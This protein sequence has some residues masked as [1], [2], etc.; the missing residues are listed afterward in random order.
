M[1]LIVAGKEHMNTF[2]LM[3]IYAFMHSAA[4]K[5]AFRLSGKKKSMPLAM[6]ITFSGLGVHEKA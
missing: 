6:L 4:N 3:C 2:T 1:L 5:C